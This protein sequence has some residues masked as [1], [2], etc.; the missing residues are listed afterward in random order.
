MSN[1]ETALRPFDTSPFGIRHSTFDID[2]G[3]SLLLEVRQMFFAGV[4][5]CCCCCCRAAD[6]RAAVR[7]RD[8]E[9]I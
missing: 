4:Q 8:E 6:N 7:T 9:R 1:V 3:G 2:T 5:L